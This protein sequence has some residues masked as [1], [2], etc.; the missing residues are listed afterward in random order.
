MYVIPVF[1]QMWFDRLK[2][3]VFNIVENGKH[4]E[5]VKS[6]LLSLISNLNL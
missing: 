5:E 2:P 6:L 3:W 4:Y 1:A